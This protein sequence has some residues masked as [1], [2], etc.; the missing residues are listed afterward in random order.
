MRKGDEQLAAQRQF[1]AEAQTRLDLARQKRRE[2][3]EQVEEKEVQCMHKLNSIS[4]ADVDHSE[5]VWKSFVDKRR[6]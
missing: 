1:E 6:H 2:D 4:I 3:K 5:D